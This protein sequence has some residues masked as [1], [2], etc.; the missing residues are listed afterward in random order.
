MAAWIGAAGDTAEASRLYAAL[1]PVYERIL[2]REHPD[3]LAVR[4]D[5]TFWNKQAGKGQRRRGR[6]K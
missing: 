5:L 4:Q 6:Q 1:L 2:G 3:T